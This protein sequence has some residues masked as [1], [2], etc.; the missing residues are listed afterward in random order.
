MP[1]RTATRRPQL[2]LSGPI[3]P[4]KLQGRLAASYHDQNGF[5]T[6]V[7]AGGYANP[8]EQQSVHGTL[9]WVS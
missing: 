8:L 3:V 7:N 2:S 9:R 1:T 4:G 5:L 6:N